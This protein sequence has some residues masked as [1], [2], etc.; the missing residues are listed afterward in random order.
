MWYYSENNQQLGPVSEDD[1]KQKARRGGLNPTT[2]VWKDGMSDWKPIAELPELAIAIQSAPV[3][4]SNVLGPPTAGQNPYASP[5]SGMVQRPAMQM[6]PAASQINS[7]GILAFAIVSTVMCCPPFG[8][9]AIVYA[10]KI[11]GQLS[12]GDLM[13]AQE[14]ARKA[15]MWSWIAI[16]SWLLLIALYFGAIFLGIA[17]GALQ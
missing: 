4:T 1:L 7:G 2:L 12:V 13:G 6:S 15:K 11:T 14:S 3:A 16:G 17:A 9:P 8:I 10:A 5:Q